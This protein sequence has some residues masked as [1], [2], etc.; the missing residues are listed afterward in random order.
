MT[1]HV[2]VSPEFL[3][4]LQRIHNNASTDLQ[5]TGNMASGLSQSV[6][7]THGSYCSL[8]NNAFAQFE[9]IRSTAV[10]RLQSVAEL[11]ADNLHKAGTAYQKADEGGADLIKQTTFQ[12]PNF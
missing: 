9:T 2:H 8:F 1:G 7:T 12:W 4:A 5:S 10:S 3:N 11:L 6:S